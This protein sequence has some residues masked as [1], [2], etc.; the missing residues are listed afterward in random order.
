MGIQKKH[1]WDSIIVSYDGS[2]I[3]IQWYRKYGKYQMILFY[4][5]FHDTSK[6]APWISPYFFPFKSSRPSAF[7]WHQPWPC[8]LLGD[9]SA[10]FGEAIIV[11]RIS[12]GGDFLVGGDWISSLVVV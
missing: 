2:I 8:A 3:L 11:C 6:S 1:Y 9:L 12:G 4:T 10:R 5:M 7:G